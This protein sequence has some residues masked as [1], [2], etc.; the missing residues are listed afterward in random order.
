MP[1]TTTLPPDSGLGFDEVLERLRAVVSRLEEG[2]L[3]LEESLAAYEEGVGLAR[4]GHELLE[5]AERRVEELVSGR[6]GEPVAV[7]LGED[8]LVGES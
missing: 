7:A 4:S 5:R 6:G 2:N 3:S 1:E 8:D